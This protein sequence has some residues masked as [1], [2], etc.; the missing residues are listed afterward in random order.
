LALTPW[1]TNA[2]KHPD[3]FEFSEKIF[4]SHDCRGKI[5]KFIKAWANGK[6]YSGMT[7]K[8]LFGCAHCAHPRCK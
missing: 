7:D 2:V 8:Y 5:L 6:I 1:L 4:R 3:N